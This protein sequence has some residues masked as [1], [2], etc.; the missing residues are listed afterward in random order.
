MSS[1]RKAVILAAGRGTRLGARSDETPKCLLPVAGKALLDHHLDALAGAGVDDVTVVCGFEARRVMAH[2]AGRCRF[3]VNDRYASTN[4]IVSLHMAGPHVR[5]EAFLFQNA[6]VLY[7]PELVR[8]FVGAPHA[9]ACLVDPLRPRAEG[10]YHVALAA[11]RIADY[12][13]AVS[14]ERSVGQSAQLVKV[15]A[16]DSAAFIGRLG[17]V[18]AAGG[19]TGFPLQAYHVLMAGEGLWP[20]YTAGLSWWEIDTLDDYERCEAAHAPNHQNGAGGLSVAKVASFLRE[21]RVP[22]RYQWLW[23]TAR[24]GFRHPMRTMRHAP[25]VRAGQLSIAGLDL[26]VNGGRLLGIALDEA[27]R[28]GLEPFLLWGS[29]LGCVRDGAFIRNDRDI[30]LGVLGSDAPRLAAWRTAM[31]A[32]GFGVRIEDAHKVSVVHSRHPR[33]FID[34]DIVHRRPDGW[35]ITNAAADPHRVYHYV[36]REPVFGETRP[37]A[38]GGRPVR[39]PAEPEGFLEATY[40][41]WR[42]PQAKL[43]YLYGPLNLEIESRCASATSA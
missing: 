29:L 19:H 5:G 35:V 32:R 23:P 24:V 39:L 21:A 28:A 34:I 37:G 9:N 17:E 7:A 8:R 30:D 18:I 12:S 33:L 31:V 16:A 27:E 25:A 40:G 10:E 15:G 2:A 20:V 14:V 26:Q 13:L 22:Y 4:S 36:F 41:E 1:C 42:T 6:D 3:V 11:G 43:H 38:L